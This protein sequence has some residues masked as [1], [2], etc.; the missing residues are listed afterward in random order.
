MYGMQNVF[1]NSRSLPHVKYTNDITN[2]SRC[3]GLE[4]CAVAQ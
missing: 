1:L 4:D 3:V 2:T